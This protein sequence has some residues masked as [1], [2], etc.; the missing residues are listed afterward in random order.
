MTAENTRIEA[1]EIPVP[2]E[3]DTSMSIHHVK[4]STFRA[5]A[6][7]ANPKKIIRWKNEGELYFTMDV[8]INGV[9]VTLFTEHSE[10]EI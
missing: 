3:N 10:L 6:L 4:L 8:K 9:T 2:R 1:G 5:L 7:V